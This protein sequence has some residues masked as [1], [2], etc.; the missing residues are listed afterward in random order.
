MEG[1][2]TRHVR[3]QGGVLSAS[4]DVGREGEPVLPRCLTE[5]GPFW[6]RVPSSYLLYTSPTRP[7]PATRYVA[8]LP[9]ISWLDMADLI[10]RFV[11]VPTSPLGASQVAP[12]RDK[13]QEVKDRISALRASG[14]LPPAS[15]AAPAP[16][17]AP[18]A[19]TPTATTSSSSAPA[20]A[21]AAAAAP[22]GRGPSQQDMAR[23][24][25][26]IQKNPEML[27]QVGK[28]RARPARVLS[29]HGCEASHKAAAGRARYRCNTGRERCENAHF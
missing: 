20:T 11:T 29:S 9:Y 4:Q 15:A 5:P 14:Q 27:K 25:E 1:S 23:A 19:P 3:D 7:P 12:I 10:V 2:L 28:G 21:A 17:P 8:A 13:L 16:A 22:S 6:A 18:V 26:L 24:A